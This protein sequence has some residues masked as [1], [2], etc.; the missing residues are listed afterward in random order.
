[1]KVG[2]TQA[3]A[4]GELQGSAARKL[5]V[6]MSDD[7]LKEIAQLVTA[8]AVEVADL[9]E[10]KR[11]KVKDFN[12]RIAEKEETLFRFA[13]VYADGGEEQEIGVEIYASIAN[14]TKTVVRTDTG[15][16]VEQS[17]LTAKEREALEQGKLFSMDEEKPTTADD[18]EDLEDE[19]S[20]DDEEE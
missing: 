9:R 3:P 5:V 14:N 7:R 19:D 8:S 16:V 1:M 11:A 6:R 10:Q 20:D 2:R 15:D 12:G 17:A 13:K 18:D 4:F